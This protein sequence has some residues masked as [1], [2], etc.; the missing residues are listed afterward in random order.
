MGELRDKAKLF[1]QLNAL[2]DWQAANS[3][4]GISARVIGRD[5]NQWFNTVVID[6]G[7]PAGVSK[8]QPVVTADGLVGRVI[9]VT[10]LASQ[11][12]LITDERHGAG[13]AGLQRYV[14]RRSDPA[15]S[16]DGR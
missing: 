2:K 12:L 1:D 14:Q 3:Y 4:S 15:S 7:M 9:L 6:Q 13:A 11:V 5:P 10:P 16:I 8:K